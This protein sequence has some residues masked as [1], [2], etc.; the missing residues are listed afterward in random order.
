MYTTI[1]TS[2]VAIALTGI[3]VS[4]WKQRS[5]S[6]YWLLL[7]LPALF[8]LSDTIEAVASVSVVSMVLVL[9]YGFLCLKRGTLKISF[10]SSYLGIGDVLLFFS[11]CLVFQPTEMIYLFVYSSILG[12]LLGKIINSDKVPFTIPIVLSTL[13]IWLG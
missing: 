3:S 7:L 4:D 8:Y 10:F 13:L 5:Y 9:T 6:V 11:L 2:A 1:A 12:L